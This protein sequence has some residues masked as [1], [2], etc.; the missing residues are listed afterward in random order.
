M[1]NSVFQK[2]NS[3]FQDNFL[4]VSQ[5]PRPRYDPR[6]IF[7]IYGRITVVGLCNL[8]AMGSSQ[9]RSQGSLIPVQSRYVTN[10]G[11]VYSDICAVWNSLFLHWWAYVRYVER[12]N[13]CFGLK[14]AIGHI[15]RVTAVLSFSNDL[16][17]TSGNWNQSTGDITVMT[18][19]F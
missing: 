14:D 18:E 9:I 15:K 4:F 10:G 16:L 5:N 12:W 13:N 6:S 17:T 8:G 7:C 19:E 2:N 11:K 1:W 3:V